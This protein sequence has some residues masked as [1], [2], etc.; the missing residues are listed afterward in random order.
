[1]AKKGEKQSAGILPDQIKVPMSDYVVGKCL[2]SE[3]RVHECI[4]KLNFIKRT[5]L[6]GK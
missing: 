5:A 1:M 3:K 2:H 6:M 4:N